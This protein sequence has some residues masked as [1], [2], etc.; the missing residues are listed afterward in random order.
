[1][2]VSSRVDDFFLLNPI[3]LLPAEVDEAT[4]GAGKIAPGMDGLFQQ[5]IDG[6][7]TNTAPGAL[8][9]FN[10]DCILFSWLHIKLPLVAVVG[11]GL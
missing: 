3:Y 9:A 5:F 10:P 7:M 8:G 11:E 1:L 6:H 2:P 4:E